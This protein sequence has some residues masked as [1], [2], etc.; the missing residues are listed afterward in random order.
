MDFKNFEYIYFAFVL[1]ETKSFLNASQRLNL[2]QSTFSRKISELEKSL[3]IKIFTRS[4][5]GVSTTAAGNDFLNKYQHLYREMNS[6][7]E[8][9]TDQSKLNISINAPLTFSEVILPSIINKFKLMNPE[10]SFKINSSNEFVSQGAGFD[11]LIKGGRKLRNSEML[12]TKLCSLSTS[13][14]VKKGSGINSYDALRNYMICW[15]GSDNY[16]TDK[17]LET[18]HLV[19]IKIP[20]APDFVSN[21]FHVCR[22]FIL[23]GK[24]VGFLPD[25]FL[26]LYPSDIE[27]T[28][29]SWVGPEFDFYSLTNKKSPEIVKTFIKFLKASSST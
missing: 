24:T 6:F 22:N 8:S 17:S 9:S 1:N 26:Q 13:L 23:Q 29:D 11:I 16:F 2:P 14:Y 20:R 7:I 15:Y 3:A 10:V 28:K 12:Q 27:R 18:N 5:H 19:K 4:S 21:N 25:K